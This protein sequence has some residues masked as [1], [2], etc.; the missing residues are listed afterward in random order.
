MMWAIIALM[1]LLSVPGLCLMWMSALEAIQVSR[2]SHTIT[3]APLRRAFFL[4][5]PT[6]GWA[7]V[8]LAPIRN[9]VW[10]FLISLMELVIAPEPKAE[11]SPATVGAGQAV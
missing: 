7:S 2:G 5:S 1:R 3:L 10:T 11:A 4:S 8:G 9:I 6:T